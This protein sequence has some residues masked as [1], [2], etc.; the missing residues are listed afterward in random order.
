MK[1]MWA[2]EGGPR[3]NRQGKVVPQ[4]GR[5]IEGHFRY[6]LN[7]PHHLP[8]SHTRSHCHSRLVPTQSGSISCPERFSLS[9]E[10][11][12][13]HVQS[14]IGEAGPLEALSGSRGQEMTDKHPC[15]APLRTSMTSP[16][17]WRTKGRTQRC[18]FLSPVLLSLTWFF[19]PPPLRSPLEILNLF[20]QFQ[21]QAGS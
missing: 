3:L 21:A 8:A 14:G 15:P 16:K 13:H 1:M 6:P 18:P 11:R 19:L 4:M 10:K 7:P 20:C 9:E 17:T 2:R 12:H 5:A